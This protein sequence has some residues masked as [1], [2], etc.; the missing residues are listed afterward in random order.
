MAASLTVV[1]C[2]RLPQPAQGEGGGRVC[3][4]QV[5]LA[6]VANRTSLSLFFHRQNPPPTHTTGTGRERQLSTSTA[7]GKLLALLLFLGQS[8]FWRPERNDSSQLPSYL[9]PAQ[10]VSRHCTQV[11]I[12][13]KSKENPRKNACILHNR[14]TR[15]VR[16]TN[17]TQ[18]DII[19][20]SAPN[21]IHA[22]KTRHLRAVLNQAKCKRSFCI[23]SSYNC[24]H[25]LCTTTVEERCN[26][27][28]FTNSEKI[29]SLK[30]T[31]QPHIDV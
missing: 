3:Q 25:T 23:I 4:R 9:I 13:Q 6:G 8:S 29:P 10:K 28:A 17:Y 30:K 21:L 12:G 11:E 18:H 22:E 5:W 16:T 24:P 15:D 20:D 2:V 31:P 19:V 7:C 26:L 27:I 1:L 14:R